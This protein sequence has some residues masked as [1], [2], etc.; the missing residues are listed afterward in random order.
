[1]SE[2]FF[3]WPRTGGLVIGLASAFYLPGTGRMIAIPGCATTVLMAVND[4]VA[5][6]PFRNG[7]PTDDQEE[8]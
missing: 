2:P 6:T 5:G 8:S 1:M 7:F 4:G 3:L